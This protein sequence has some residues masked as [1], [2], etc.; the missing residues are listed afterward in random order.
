MGRFI[1]FEGIEGSGKSTQINLTS[2]WL[3]QKGIAHIVTRDP[4]GTKA[5]ETI[6][7]L[8]LHQTDAELAPL[9][10]VTLFTAARH[11]LMHEIILPALE[12]N[13]WVLCDR[14][15]DSTIAYQGHGRGVGEEIVRSL[16]SYTGNQMPDLT[17]VLDVEVETGLH[18]LGKEVKDRFESLDFSFHR[19]VRDAY[20]QLAAREP[21]RIELLDASQPVE[22][23]QKSIREHL[24]R[25]CK[26]T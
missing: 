18:R 15:I 8:L 4:G 12:R 20:L 23:I 17:F 25:W 7:R 19:R 24:N 26:S 2:T 13:S 10:E 9:T 11:Q 6:R 3:S 5:G 14:F 21:N 1:T 22:A 16:H